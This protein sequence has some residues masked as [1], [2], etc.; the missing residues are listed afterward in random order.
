MQDEMQTNGGN[1]NGHQTPKP[2]T[3]NLAI[4]ILAA[5]I[6]ILLIVWFQTAQAPSE[7][8]VTDNEVSEQVNETSEQISGSS[9]EGGTPNDWPNYETAMTN[10]QTLGVGQVIHESIVVDPNDVD[11][12]YFSTS[13]YNSDIDENLISIY[14]YNE[15][16]DNFERLFRTRYR[17]G[18]T[19]LLDEAMVPKMLTVGY[20]DGKLILLMMDY[21]DELDTCE[22]ALLTGIGDDRG[23]SRNLLS[24]DINDPYAGFSEYAPSNEQ[25][26]EAEA[27]EA[28]CEK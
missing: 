27:R 9:Y 5:I 2:K 25:I 18:A 11:L 3:S 28:D 20:E 6:V 16:N 19:S 17:R 26:A 4:G 15:S 22:E 10:I 12:V 21:A 7:D 14:R 23:E 8:T 1:T 13:A 24:M